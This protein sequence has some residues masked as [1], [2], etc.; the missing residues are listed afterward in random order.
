MALILTTAR[1]RTLSSF[2]VA[3]TNIHHSLEDLSGVLTKQFVFLPV[4]P[5]KSVLRARGIHDFESLPPD[6]S[7]LTVPE[8]IKAGTED[9][10]S[11]SFLPRPSNVHSLY[12]QNPTI[13][14]TALAHSQWS[15]VLRPGVDSAIDATAG[16]GHDSLALAKL[17]FPFPE[18]GS[19]NSQLV[20]LDVQSAACEATR[21]RLTRYFSG[22]LQ[23]DGIDI[24]HQSH[25]TLPTTLSSCA[26]VC[27]NLGYLP[28][29]NHEVSTQV[30][31]TLASLGQATSMLRVGGMLSVL[32]YPGSNYE[33]H[34]L[35][36]MF[37][38]GL[39]GARESNTVQHLTGAWEMVPADSHWRVY[40]HKPLAWSD[41]PVLYTAVRIK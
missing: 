18:E 27:Y 19:S 26:L 15:Y 25:V 7:I 37:V 30:S 11:S 21:A 12:R 29:Y 31:S 6:T 35:V 2:L 8:S 22:N 36:R 40:E 3:K 28:G 13:S 32:T 39:G 20:C 23:K 5:F 10:N 16:N 9:I 4:L 34:E 38:E 33:E 24:L 41:A 14:L 1:L 17:L